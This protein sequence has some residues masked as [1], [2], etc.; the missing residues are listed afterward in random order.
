MKSSYRNID[1]TEENSNETD[2]DQEHAAY[3]D[4]KISSETA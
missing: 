4:T 2:E 3:L 1:E